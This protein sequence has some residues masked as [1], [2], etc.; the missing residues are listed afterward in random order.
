[1]G[2]P[3][4]AGQAS[5]H[6][7][8]V[9]PNWRKRTNPLKAP[10]AVSIKSLRMVHKTSCHLSFRISRKEQTTKQGGRTRKEDPAKKTLP[11]EKKRIFFSFKRVYV[12]FLWFSPLFARHVFSLFLNLLIFSAFDFLVP[13]VFYF[14]SSFVYFVSCVLSFM[15]IK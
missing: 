3:Q 1:M 11:K 10:K 14:A 7:L 6:Q 4:W 8:E 12:C 13:V 15:R 5:P 9:T 2:L